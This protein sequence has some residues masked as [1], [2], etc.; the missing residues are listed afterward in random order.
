MPINSR[1]L[2]FCN[3]DQEVTVAL[4]FHSML[5]KY[6][7]Y[8][9]SMTFQRHILSFQA[10]AALHAGARKAPVRAPSLRI[11]AEPHMETHA[12]TTNVNLESARLSIHLL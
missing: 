12:T 9:T 1:D 7:Q 2:R 5:C 3:I 8:T 6:L 10:K 11:Q 4:S